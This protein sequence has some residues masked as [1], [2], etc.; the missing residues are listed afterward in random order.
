[1]AH[2]A[3]VY[4]ARCMCK[5]TCK[6]VP[7]MISRSALG[8]S[9]VWRKYFS[10]RSSPKNTTSGFTVAAQNEQSG[11]LSVM[12]AACGGER[13]RDITAPPCLSDTASGRGHQLYLH[14][15]SRKRSVAQVTGRRAE[16]AVSFHQLVVR[17]AANCEEEA[18]SVSPERQTNVPSS[19]THASP[20]HRCSACT[21]AAVGLCGGAHG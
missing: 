19:L 10:G 14:L 15:G 11:T 20:G 18:V 4:I 13:E 9:L 21:C 5:Y 1:M 8:K 12:M 7:I 2:R 6:E 3:G 17:D 16:T